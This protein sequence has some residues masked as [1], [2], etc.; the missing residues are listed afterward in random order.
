MTNEDKLRIYA[1]YLPYKLQVLSHSGTIFQLNTF[2]ET[3][4]KGI[5]NRC[6]ESVINNNYKPIIYPLEFLTKEIEHEGKLINIQENMPHLDFEWLIGKP[7][8]AFKLNQEDF[9]ILVKHHFNVFNLPESEYIN[10][11][12]LTNK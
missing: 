11:A 12:T 2:N 5:E 6:I 7:E 3:K 10:K 9:E 4:G 8:L 1:A